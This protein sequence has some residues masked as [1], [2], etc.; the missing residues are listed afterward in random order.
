MAENHVVGAPCGIM[1]QIAITS[2]RREKMTHILC[3]PGKV[4]GEVEIPPGTGF[5]GINSMV[6]HSVGGNPYSDTRIGAFMGKKII[7]GVRARTGRAQLT[8][9]T[10]MTVEELRSQYLPEI[11]ETIVGSEFLSKFKT[12]DDPVTTIQPDAVYRVAGPTRHPV[13]ENE[14]VLKFIEALSAANNGSDERAL[15]TAGEMMYGAHESYRDNCKLS[16]DEVDF[17]VEAVRKRGPG[18]GLYGAK[19]TGGGTGG[20]VAVF[21]KLEALEEHIPQIAVEYSRRVGAMPDIFEG[22]S[23]GA[24][25]FGARRYLFGANG[26][27]GMSA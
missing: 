27:K 14:R 16:V 10:E 23:P 13:E 26:W 20:T 12:H 5:V 19:I 3:R 17:L 6:R 11:P 18:C 15:I 8:Y 7:N 22:T 21:G 25:E 9:L 24:V 4:V 1:D 2:G